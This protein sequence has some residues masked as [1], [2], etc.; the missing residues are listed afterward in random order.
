M[1]RRVV[2]GPRVKGGERIMTSSISPAWS[3]QIAQRH[4]GIQ[5]A[6]HDIFKNQPP[7]FPANTCVSERHLQRGRTCAQRAGHVRV[8][9][10][11]HRAYLSA[12]HRQTH[13][14][15]AR[16]LCLCVLIVFI[17]NQRMSWIVNMLTCSKVFFSLRKHNYTAWWWL[18]HFAPPKRY[19]HIS[20]SLLVHLRSSRTFPPSVYSTHRES[21]HEPFNISTR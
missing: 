9:N 17:H 21:R 16:E 18:T 19:R 14:V 6:V 3:Q 10:T 2:G 13:S 4:T 20:L 15:H 1:K 8:W 11:A 5:A 7:T 12:V